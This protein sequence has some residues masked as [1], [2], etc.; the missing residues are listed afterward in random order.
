VT[1]ALESG[2]KAADLIIRELRGERIDWQSE[3]AD[4]MMIGIEVFREFVNAWY[5]GRLQEILFTP[6]KADKIVRRIVSVLSGYVWDETN[7]FV[8]SPTKAVNA[9]LNALTTAHV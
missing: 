4:Y 6:D 3:Y 9:T 1:L 8:T 2:S 7:M 5:D